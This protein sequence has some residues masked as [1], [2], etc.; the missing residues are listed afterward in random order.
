M[1]MG[2]CGDVVG[3][4]GLLVVVGDDAAHQGSGV[5]AGAAARH[6]HTGGGLGVFMVAFPG[7]PLIQIESELR[8]QGHRPLRS[9]AA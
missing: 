9:P 7:D 6:V 5:S 3:G 4:A 2:F 8:R 1:V